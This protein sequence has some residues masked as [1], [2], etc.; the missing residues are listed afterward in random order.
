[1]KIATTKQRILEF[2]DYKGIN[3]PS[4]FQETDI[5]RGFLDGDKLDSSVSDAFIAKIIARY[6]EINL[7]WL[8]TG[9]GEM[10]K[11]ETPAVYQPRACEKN[12]EEQEIPLYDINAAAGL[13]S[14]FAGG[15]QNVIDTLRI[16]HLSKV[17][18]AMS[19]TGDSMYP[20]LKSGDIV[21]FKQ[22]NNIEYLHFGNIYI[23]AYQIDGDE[24]VVVKYINESEK[25]GFIKLVSYNEHYKPIDIPVES[26]AS[27]AL[28]K[29]SIRFNTMQ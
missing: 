7:E 17:D 25:K 6:P 3:L 16:P 13:N 22:I 26:I 1:M 19:I 28:V 11:V 21:V 12:H 10:L 20:L 27:I 18:G 29:A 4:F 14:L 2:I 5:K 15:R 8:I 24:Y 9:K 23:L